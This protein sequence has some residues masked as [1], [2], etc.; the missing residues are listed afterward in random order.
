MK[1]LTLLLITFLTTL[2][3]A[4]EITL[5]NL[6]SYPN[7][8]QSSK[9]AVQWA[10]SASEIDEGNVSMMH[11]MNQNPHSLEMI[12]KSGRIRLM[13]PDNAEYFR[14]LVWSDGKDNP[15]LHTNWVL[16]NSG[17]TYPL[18][19]EQLVPSVLMSGSGC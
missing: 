3:Y 12:T 17:K 6:T 9:M 14:V 8:R 10:T 7:R 5:D 11:D 2:A 18:T 19:N 13:V 4:E 15:N 16:I 1:K